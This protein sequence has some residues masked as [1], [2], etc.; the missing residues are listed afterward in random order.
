MGS[1]VH[2]F[3]VAMGRHAP[4]AFERAW[5]QS[6]SP[7]TRHA[8]IHIMATVVD[9]YIES[10]NRMDWVGLSSTIT[11]D[12]FERVG[13]FQDVVG[14][15]G[16]YVEFLERVVSELEN[17]QVRPR[18][19]VP[20]EGV[21]YAEVVESFIFNG[22]PMAFPECLVFDLAGD[23]LISRVQV[24]MMRPGEQPSVPGARA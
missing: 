1:R 8:M 19:L 20:S 23:G 22:T 14:S 3:A 7:G 9:R 2:G 16:E 4:F 10:L 12:G 5:K 11:A 17:Y 24:Y 6:L 18:R 15:R 21:V 13:P